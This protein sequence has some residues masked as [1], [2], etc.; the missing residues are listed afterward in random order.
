MIWAIQVVRRLL[1]FAWL[2]MVLWMGCAAPTVMSPIDRQDPQRFDAC[3]DAEGRAA[4]EQAL[5]KLQAGDDAA[6]VPL[7]QTVVAR[8]PEHVQAMAYYQDAA[9]HVGG[10]IEAQMRA[11]YAALADSDESPLP[12]FAKA[13]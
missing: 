4:Y 10:G 1:R 11:W 13:R 3:A 5:G 2:A 8:C 6:A 7:L 12:A 9:M